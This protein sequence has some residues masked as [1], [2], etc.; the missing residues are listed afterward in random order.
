MDLLLIRGAINAVTLYLFLL[1]LLVFSIGGETFYIYICCLRAYQ[2][3]LFY[4]ICEADPL[5]TNGTC[6]FLI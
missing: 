6:F 4:R 2:N 5:S 1:F 3:I